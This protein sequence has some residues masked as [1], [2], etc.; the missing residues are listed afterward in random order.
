MNVEILQQHTHKLFTI[1]TDSSP[2]PMP[3]RQ[4]T[5]F[6][7]Q[8]SQSPPLDNESVPYLGAWVDQMNAILVDGNQQ[9][10]RILWLSG[11]LHKA[12]KKKKKSRDMMECHSGKRTAGM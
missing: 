10:L 2:Q 9:R 11:L 7:K 1:N 3:V 4:L 8:R 5:K 6:R 12:M